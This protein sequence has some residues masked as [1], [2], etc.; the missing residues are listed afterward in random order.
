MDKLLNLI[1]LAKKAGKLEVGEEPV[2]AAARSKHARLILIASDAAE[3]TRRRAKHFGD[4]GECIC[5][6]IPATKEALG[7]ALGRTSCALLAL[8]DIGFA[9]AIAKK[10]AESDEAHYGEAAK[11]LSVKAARAAERRAELKQHEKNLRAGKKKPRKEEPAQ[12]EEIQPAAQ[13]EET[14]KDEQSAEP[15]AEEKEIDTKNE[16]I[17]LVIS[18]GDEEPVQTEKTKDEAPAEAETEKE[19][20]VVNEKEKKDAK[21][22][23]PVKK[24][25]A[26][27]EIGVTV[28]GP[29]VAKV[30]PGKVY[31]FSA[32]VSCAVEGYDIV[33]SVYCSDET[34]KAS[35]VDG[36]LY[37]TENPTG[38][39][40]VL[41]IRARYKDADGKTK[42]AHT[43]NNTVVA[44][45]RMLIAFVENHLQA[46]GSVTIPAV[47]QPYM[48]GK[49]VITPNK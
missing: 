27:A 13:P 44:P 25:E 33:W 14:Q 22:Q 49:K 26:P 16:N 45:P 48:G 41:R 34:V 19:T 9:E 12:P 11:R 20:V 21:E 24:E 3:N 39:D 7:K 32:E 40:Q 5:L 47:L 4:A 38:E 36:E 30:V 17:K 8:T 43:L 46:D 42:L 35:I 37:V 28:Y 29:D 6:E 23:K 18:G 31:T 10:L 15:A 2:G 1:G